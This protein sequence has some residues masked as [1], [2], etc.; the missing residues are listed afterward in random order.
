MSVRKFMRLSAGLCLAVFAVFAVSDAVAGGYVTVRA[1]PSLPDSVIE[2]IANISEPRNLSIPQGEAPDQFIKALCG[3]YTNSFGKVFFKLNQKLVPQSTGNP[4]HVTMPACAKWKNSDGN[5]LLVSVLPGEVLDDVLLRNI[6]RT[7]NQVF[8]C[9]PEAQSN[10][11]GQTFFALVEK[12]NQGR[13]LANFRLGDSILLP[14]VTS[15]ST[16]TIRSDADV[17]VD[18]VVAKIRELSGANDDPQQSPLIRANRAPAISLVGAFDFNGVGMQE[19]SCIDVHQ[20][21]GAA[22]Q[23]WP[24]DEKLITAIIRRNLDAAK[25]RDSPLLRTTVTVLDTGLDASFPPLLQ[26]RDDSVDPRFRFGIGIER[27]DNILPFPSH[28]PEAARQH[29]T[30][31]AEIATGFPTLQGAYPDLAALFKLNVVNLMESAGDG[32]YEITSGGLT[33]AIGWFV[34]QSHGDIASISIASREEL[35]G[36]KSLMQQNPKLLVVAAAGNDSEKLD[37]PESQGLYPADYGGE[38]EN[39]GTQFITVGAYAGNLARASFSNFGRRYVDLLAPGC[40]IPYAANKPGVTGTSFAAPLVSMTA[41]LLHAFG[42]DSSTEIKRRLQASVDYDQYLEDIVLWSG[43]LNIAKSLSVYEDVLERRSSKELSFGR[44]TLSG[45]VCSDQSFDADT[46]KK[47]SVRSSPD[48]PLKIRVLWADRQGKL[49]EAICER[50]GDTLP[51]SGT[52][53]DVPWTDLVDFVPRYLGR[54]KDIFTTS[55]P[56]G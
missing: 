48:Q 13:D 41:A 6:G 39:T 17:T 2:Y 16:F 50:L 10:R 54:Y 52:S 25:N 42:L 15:P 19:Q 44:W 12:L 34:G 18:E 20:P 35:P 51:I 32:E 30:E 4:R 21:A 29:G 46:I 53:E 40:D 24:Y 38:A 49:T 31:V 27:R 8:K 37:S 14:F 11:C 7:A 22:N 43:R 3:N 28:T 26:R 1:L 5:G 55:K 56:G 9:F 33:T 23:T 45:D 36:L 47:I